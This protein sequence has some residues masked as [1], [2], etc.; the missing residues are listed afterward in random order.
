MHPEQETEEPRLMPSEMESYFQ[1]DRPLFLLAKGY[2]ADLQAGDRRAASERIL[3]SVE[4]GTTVADSILDHLETVQADIVGI[5]ATIAPHVDLVSQ[6]IQQLKSRPSLAKV[7]VLV[8]GY[9]FNQD[10]SLWQSLGADG[11]ASNADEAI[12]GADRLLTLQT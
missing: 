2:F 5:S 1:P 9:P 6:F 3:G 8:G 4:Q 11:F 10:A 12:A 7:R